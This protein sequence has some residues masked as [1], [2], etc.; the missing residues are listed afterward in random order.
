MPDPAQGDE[1]E[2]FLGLRGRQR[3]RD[4]AEPLLEIPDLITV[5]VIRGLKIEIPVGRAHP[6]E[7]RSDR[8]A[9]AAHLLEQAG[10]ND[11]AA[12]WRRVMNEEAPAQHVADVEGRLGGVDR[13]R[14]RCLASYPGMRQHGD[15]RQEPLGGI[16]DQASP[17]DDGRHRRLARAE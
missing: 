4:L 5:E 11:V 8:A 6:G 2:R 7:Q 9:S 12:L 13:R 17:L 14:L 16:G 15:Q 3:A 10:H 1:V